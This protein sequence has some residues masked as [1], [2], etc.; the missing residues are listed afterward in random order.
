MRSSLADKRLHHCQGLRLGEIV[1]SNP[2]DGYLVISSVQL[3]LLD[4]DVFTERCAL[5]LP[6]GRW[7]LF[8][9]QVSGCLTVNLQRL[10]GGSFPR[11]FPSL[12]PTALTKPLGSEGIKDTFHG[13]GYFPHILGRY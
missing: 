4:D 5:I 10:F 1:E 6:P 7:T 11:E 8:V 2:A 9:K 13:C 12:S 3:F